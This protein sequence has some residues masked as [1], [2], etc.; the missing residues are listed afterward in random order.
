[1]K[2]D[3]TATIKEIGEIETVGQKGFQKRNVVLMEI[4]GQYENL[5]AVEFSGDK[6]QDPERYRVGQS[7]KVGGFVNC[8][9]WQGKYFTSLKGSFIQN[10]EAEQA[11]VAQMGQAGYVAQ[12]VAQ[13][14][15]PQPVAQPIYQAPQ[16]QAQPVAPIAQAIP[17]NMAPPV[18]QNPSLQQ[19]GVVPKQLFNADGSPFVAED[20]IPY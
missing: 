8:N 3:V 19:Q 1:M 6:L 9:E 10:A 18:L 11:P 16:V 7:V 4:N 13:P 15:A 5:V 12:P 20:E 17:A 14:Q 2:F